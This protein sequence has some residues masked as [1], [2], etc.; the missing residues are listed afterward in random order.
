MAR[1]LP[2]EPRVPAAGHRVA[3]SR[4]RRGGLLVLALCTL[5]SAC[6][7][8]EAAEPARP[9]GA[10]RLPG[11]ADT[12]LAQPP[13]E[14]ASLGRAL[15]FDTRLSEPPG[16]SCASC[17]DPR[18]A[19]ATPRDRT[20]AGVTPGAVP[21]R[22]GARNAPSLMYA[23]L[24]P[25]PRYD[26]ERGTVVG[27]LLLDQRAESLEAQAAHPLFN[28]LEMANTS[29]AALAE[30]LRRAPYAAEFRRIFGPGAL[31]DPG[32]LVGYATRALAAFQRT[33]DFMPFSSKYD[34]VV[35][36]LA[37]FSPA[38]ARGFEVFRDP[39]RGDCVQCHA[40]DQ[41]PGGRSL[42]TDFSSHN[43]GLPRNPANPH[44]G[45]PPS[46]NP[47]GAQF[48]DRGVG[49]DPR[50]PGLDGR[51]RVPTL[52]NIAITSP[53]MHHGGF[54]SLGEV[55]R[56]Y[57]T[58]CLPGN[59]AGWDPPEVD[60]RDC[61][62]FARPALSPRDSADL[63][64]FMYALTDGWFDPLTGAPGYIQ[65]SAATE[66]QIDAPPRPRSGR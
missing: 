25:P 58:A 7:M 17:H 14:L 32:R 36:G 48:V 42:F 5:L 62:R 12:P 16:Q 22:F 54:S 33:A 13:T 45:L 1:P 49:A 2:L 9:S 57:A 34:A 38:E 40:I 59:P 28:P 63:V 3:S 37:A 30:R 35:A 15:F 19:F 27:G 31:D 24:V 43:L 50:R 51:F 29:P 61:R 6:G 41:G 20:Q 55:V 4:P 10:P 65:Q 21:G 44:Y 66:A 11:S 52:R 26:I 47:Q 53:Y 39:A 23:A 18:W 60:G 56:F 46:L 8:R 64:A